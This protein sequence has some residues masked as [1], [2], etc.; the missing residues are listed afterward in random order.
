MAKKKLEGNIWVDS[1][2]ATLFIYLFMYV[3]SQIPAF[4]IF[5]AFDAV[6]QALEDMEMTDV[7]FSQL[8]EPLPPDTSIVLVN[9]GNLSRGGIA[10]QIRIVD[11]YDPKVIG[12]DSF[13]KGYTDTL[14][15][16]SLA[17]ALTQA[18]SEVVMVTKVEQT[19]SIA[20]L[21]LG[22]EVYDY[23]YQSDSIFIENTHQAI[24][25]LD[26]DARFQDDI[27]ICRQFPPR[28]SLTSGDTYVAFAA[29]M[30]ELYRPGSTEKL[31]K[32]DN[33]Y[34]IINYRGDFVNF[35]EEDKFST[36]FYSLDWYQVLNEDFEPGLLKD[37]IVLFGFLGAQFGAPEWEDKFFTPLNPKIAGRAN[38]DMFGPVI[39][40]NILSMILNNDYVDTYRP[41][42]EN[43]LG[44]LLCYLNVLLF[45]YIYRKYGVWYDG[46]TKLIQVIEV[47][48]ILFLIIQ[49]FST[50]SFKLELTYGLIALALAGDLLE[51]YYGVVRNLFTETGRRLMFR[52]NKRLKA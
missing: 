16:L 34:E 33:D 35:F 4:G 26:T 29:K 49:L 21:H 38:P 44:V 11:K 7:A 2:F 17:S 42:F 5:D 20:E 36:R 23:L 52:K 48:L 39:H 3:I 14:E 32:R 30:A 8:R 19:D 22:D 24:A 45:S 13:F 28:R 27:K 51:V 10:E 12:I 43:I 41:T 25:N 18:N 46:L 6:G 1:I 31:F 37:K 40:A 15:T 50:H 47:I 9:M